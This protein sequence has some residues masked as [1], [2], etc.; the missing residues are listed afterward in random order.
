M[1][2]AET[3]WMRV[4]LNGIIRNG[5]VT[6]TGEEVSTRE[7]A[8]LLGVSKR[9]MQRICEELLQEG[10][11]WRKVPALGPNGSYRIKLEAVV[12][13]KRGEV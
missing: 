4:P 5:V 7:A 3:R 9:T 1:P 11:D 10:V 6:P 8:H 12:R 13:M 2:V